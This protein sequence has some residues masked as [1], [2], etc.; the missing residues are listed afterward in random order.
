MQS[1][2]RMNLHYSANGAEKARTRAGLVETRYN[3]RG[4]RGRAP[5]SRPGPHPGPRAPCNPP[6]V[7]GERLFSIPIIA[8]IA[9]IRCETARLG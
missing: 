9:R 5:S 2:R 8:P 3:E 7:T 6:L 1:S 4:P